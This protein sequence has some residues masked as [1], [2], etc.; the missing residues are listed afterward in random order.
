MT[1][2]NETILQ[3]CEIFFRVNRR[4]K[5]EIKLV[6]CD[7]KILLI[8]SRIILELIDHDTELTFCN[9]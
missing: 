8:D 1:H 2:I 5:I 4:A 3:F 6:F 7:E 9:V